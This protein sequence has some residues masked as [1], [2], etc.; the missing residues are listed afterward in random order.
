MRAVAFNTRWEHLRE[1][2]SKYKFRYV[3]NQ[4]FSFLKHKKCYH[5][6]ISPIFGII[7][8]PSTSAHNRQK[9]TRNP[10]RRSHPR[11]LM[12]PTNPHTRKQLGVAFE[13]SKWSIAIFTAIFV[14]D[15][16]PG[17][18]VSFRSRGWSPFCWRHI[19]LRDSFECAILF[20]VLQINSSIKGNARGIWTVALKYSVVFPNFA[21]WS[22][23]KRSLQRSF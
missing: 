14:L 21:T 15:R 17:L 22:Y 13:M 1:S 23:V 7:F 6:Q 4:T 12:Q 18:E 10:G 11:T 8:C 5:Q 20:L 16:L 2:K 19:S 9:D 3:L